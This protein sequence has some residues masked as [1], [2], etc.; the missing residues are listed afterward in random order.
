MTVFNFR[1]LVFV[2][3][4]ISFAAVQSVFAQPVSTLPKASNHSIGEVVKKGTLQTEALAQVGEHVITS[5][6]ILISN[7]VEKALTVNS[8][9]DLKDKKNS[10]ETK[11]S[12][13]NQAALPSKGN[14]EAKPNQWSL[15]VGSE[16]FQKYLAQVI[17]ESVIQLEAENFAVGAV[18]QADMAGQIRL[19]EDRV[20]AVP[21]WTS[22]EVEEVELTRILNR[23]IRAQNFLKFK[24][25][26]SGVVV[27]DDEVKTYFEKNRVK[28]G[29]MPL[30]QFKEGIREVLA[31][32]QLQEKLKDWFEVLKRKYHFKM[33]GQSI[34][35]G[36]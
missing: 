25:E 8:N 7:F 19:V 22:L 12:K 28:F 34:A 17:L 24:M 32:E 9:V 6:E 18:T 23:K 35:V 31:Q 33:L 36:K 10:S 3:L 11:K 20:R 16:A 13:S 5:R 2:G 14:L 15:T 27:S 21:E 30:D 29:N 1:S 26:T 4:L